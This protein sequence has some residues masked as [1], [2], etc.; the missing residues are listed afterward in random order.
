MTDK[1]MVAELR[2]FAAKGSFNAAVADRLENYATQAEALQEEIRKLT[3]LAQDGQSAIDTNAHLTAEIEHQQ[4]RIAALLQANEEACVA[5]ADLFDSQQ[6]RIDA[7]RERQ[8]WTPANDAPRSEGRYLVVRLDDVTKTSF[9][10]ILWYE[11]HNWWNRHYPGDYR[12]T[13]WMPLPPLP[14]V[15]SK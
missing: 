5:A 12:V 15:K 11:K 3:A 4:R 6:R 13:H 14:E 7:L 2:V 10:D 9:I 8:R 1:E